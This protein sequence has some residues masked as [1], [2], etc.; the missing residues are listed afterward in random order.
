[1]G[2]GRGRAD[3]AL[4]TPLP[5]ARGLGRG[6]DAEEEQVSERKRGRRPRNSK[7]VKGVILVITVWMAGARGVC[8]TAPVLFRFSGRCIR[9]DGAVH[10]G[11]LSGRDVWVVVVCTPFF[12][13][14][15]VISG[16]E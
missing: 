11:T 13:K 2:R 9:R 6:E 5:Q 3:W 14:P 10:I 1:M 15:P 16:P 4:L 12:S 7:A 8:L